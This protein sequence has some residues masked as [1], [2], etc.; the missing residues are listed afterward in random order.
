MMKKLL[1]AL[2]AS[3]MALTPFTAF[4]DE[5]DIDLISQD[6]VE[7]IELYSGEDITPLAFEFN[8]TYDEKK[9]DNNFDSE[10]NTGAPDGS[11]YKI[12][13]GTDKIWDSA[14]IDLKSNYYLSL[15]FKLVDGSTL[16]KDEN[17]NPVN[18]IVM[19]NKGNDVG[20]QFSLNGTN[21]K[22]Q[23]ASN[24][25]DTL[26][27][28]FDY[29]KWYKIELEGRMM[30][31]KCVTSATLYEYDE[32]GNAT[33]VAHSNEIVLR[34][35]SATG[36]KTY[37]YT[38]LYKGVCY[39]NE[40]AAQVWPDGVKITEESGANEVNTGSFLVLSA[41]ATINDSADNVTQPKFTWSYETD[42]EGQDEYITLEDDGT[43]SVSL[44]A[45]EQNITVTATASSKGNPAG[46]YNVKVNKVDISDETF[47]TIP[48]DG[49]SEIK[50]GENAE[51][52][53]EASK[54]GI[55]VTG[56]DAVTWSIY[57]PAN[58]YEN[59]SSKISIDENGKLTVAD[60]VIE[61][62]ILV[63][64]SS[65]P[66]GS[67]TGTYPVHIKFGDS[68]IEKVV[69][70]NACERVADGA[71]SVESFDGSRA[72]YS[73][74][75]DEWTAANFS[76]AGYTVTEMD[77]K[78]AAALAG[79][80]LTNTNNNQ[81]LNIR[82]NGGKLQKVRTGTSCDAIKDADGKEYTLDSN[83]W[84][85]IEVLHSHEENDMSL[86]LYTYDKD[87]NRSENPVFTA[88]GIVR[89]NLYEYNLLTVEK[90]T[91][92]DNVKISVPYANE[93]ALTSDDADKDI[94]AG[95]SV[96]I[97]A[98]CKRNGLPLLNFSGL[99]WS[100]LGGDGQPII[101]NEDGTIDAEISTN[102]LLTT[103]AMGPIQTLTVQAKS[104]N[105]TEEIKFT[106]HRESIFE[107]AGIRYDGGAEED[108]DAKVVNKNKIVQLT[109]NKKYEYNDDVT[110][111]LAF[112]DSATN[113]LVDVHMLN[114]FGSNYKVGVNDIP[115][116]WDIPDEDSNTTIKAFA[117]TRF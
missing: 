53:F 89:R 83:A 47:D 6:D 67:V 99:D 116:E 61:Q 3:A 42:V 36:G 87:G 21:F 25:F 63:K 76:Q 96:Q 94:A 20:P 110:F 22:N 15:D 7:D 38:T 29:N 103:R 44:D 95:A 62:D 32:N 73:A 85:H 70:Y 50:A 102:G 109:V 10:A 49:P 108:G 84:Y 23:K 14:K 31:N 86:N 101:A 51:Y 26:Y 98:A 56:S 9:I 19:T 65:V 97:T 69:A 45:A 104:G 43:L 13:D 2:I 54:G 35:F 81:M 18:Q 16:S 105:K 17:N 24:G 46:T 52:T 88:V 71:V 41:A 112:Y 106:M 28:K 72:N 92:V 37:G 78:F 60:G 93:I 1:A 34:N 30:V 57:D 8:D 115:V 27:N 80:N 117:W 12:S 68:Q 5:I 40:Y 100:V 59:H 33:Q 114:A 66:N 79:F 48:I 55:P 111:I 74:S 39:D 91:Y 113:A 107:I 77:I 58:R 90:G 64:A 4:A 82:M 75:S 11:N